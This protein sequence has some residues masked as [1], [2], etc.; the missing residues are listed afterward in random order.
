MSKRMTENEKELIIKLHL[1]GKYTTEI[2]KEINR[3]QTTI[4]RFL[5]REGYKL[6]KRGV[7]TKEDEEFII[8]EYK[9]GKTCVDI[10]NNNFKE[11]F[12]SSAMI[13]RVV[14]RHGISRGRYVKPVTLNEDYFE[15][16]DSEKK[17]Y[18]LGM[19]MADGCVIKKSEN[20]YAIKLELKVEDKYILEEFAKDVETDLIVKDYEYEYKNRANKHNAIIQLHSK[21][22]AEDLSKYGIIPNKTYTQNKLPNIP[23]EY[24]CHY[25]RGYFDGDGG[26]SLIKPKDQNIHRAKVMFCADK[27]LAQEIQDLLLKR[28]GIQSYIVDMN[29][30]GNNIYNVRFDRNEY[31]YK[32]YEYIYCNATFY[33]KRKKDKFDKFIK[34]RM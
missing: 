8:N 26:I 33:M 2:A 11:I 29:K 34:E 32:F 21:K 10:Y 20:S 30:Y 17:A 15:V 24:M 1:E 19:L 28:I 13:E 16:I 23:L 25:I 4:E 18:W 31:I 12:T 14:K 9:N 6:H 22:M 7:L 3:S 5:K 27:T